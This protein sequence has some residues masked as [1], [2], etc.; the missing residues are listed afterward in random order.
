MT[1][2]D[3]ARARV[4]ARG[5]PEMDELQRSRRP[6]LMAGVAGGI[7]GAT[8]CIGPAVGVALG[9]GLGSF[10]P[11]LG[12]YRPSL[13]VVGAMVAFAIALELLRRA[14]SS[15]AT[16]REYRSLRRR[17]LEVAMVAFAVT[18]AVGRLALPR[19]IERL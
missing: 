11:G 3:D 4:P 13:F 18:Y 15:C 9:A 8:C 7:A 14:R 19:I 2:R 16:D 10:L 5:M 12:R 17:W 6:A 1:S